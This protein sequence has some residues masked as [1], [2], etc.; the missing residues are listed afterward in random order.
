MADYHT[1]SEVVEPK[2]K[3]VRAAEAVLNDTAKV[4]YRAELNLKACQ[5]ALFELQRDLERQLE[6]KRLIHELVMN[7]GGRIDQAESLLH[8]L[9][10]EQEIWEKHGEEFE[11]Q[12]NRLAGD[13]ALVCAF[14]SYCGP[15]N[16]DFREELIRNRLTQDLLLRNIPMTERSTETK[17][18]LPYVVPNLISSPYPFHSL[19]PSLISSS[20]LSFNSRGTE[21]VWGAEGLSPDQLSLQNGLLEIGRAHV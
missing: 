1:A 6:E 8:S 12:K 3:A 10:T 21:A 20:I 9:L 2:L 14:M 17:S 16:L 15:L 11:T 4:L 7:A 18:L 19:V 13:I 5:D